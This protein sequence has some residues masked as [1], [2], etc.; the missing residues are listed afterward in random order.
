M[1]YL[2]FFA[3]IARGFL[4]LSRL[5]TPTAAGACLFLFGFTGGG[6]PL[7]AQ[8][9]SYP[10]TVHAFAVSNQGG[11]VLASDAANAETGY[12]RDR[13]NTELHIT[14]SR[15]DTSSDQWLY[16]EF[17][18]RI[19]YD[20]SELFPLRDSNGNPVTEYTRGAFVFFPVGQG[21]VTRTHEVPLTPGARFDPATYYMVQVTVERGSDLRA[22]ANTFSLYLPHF[23]H[24]EPDDEAVHVLARQEWGNY[25]RAF[26]VRTMAGGES[27][28]V[29]VP[30]TLYRWDNFEGSNTWTTIPVRFDFVLREAGTGD[31]VPLVTNTRT[32]SPWMYSYRTVTPRE[33]YT[34]NLSTTLEIE[35]AGGVQLKSA[36][37][38]Y[39]LEVT[40]SHEEVSGQ[41]YQ[42]S[43]TRT[44]ASRQL[45]HF[46]GTLYFDD[47]E[48]E[49][50]GITNEP[51]PDGGGLTYVNTTLSI[52]GDAGVVLYD[53]RFTF[54]GSTHNVRLLDDGSA[55]VQSG[56]ASIDKD[57]EEGEPDTITKAGVV[58]Q[59]GSIVLDVNGAR[60]HTVAFF[61][62]G[63]GMA[64]GSIQP[65]R[66]LI[67]Y[68][69]FIN[70]SLD[71]SLRPFGTHE[72]NRDL[73][74]WMVD[75][76][77]PFFIESRSIAWNADSG[78]FTVAADN[79]RY[80][81]KLWL[82]SLEYEEEQGVIANPGATTR[83]SNDQYY[84]FVNGW[85]SEAV[86]RAG[87]N[88]NAEMDFELSL[89]PG[90]FAPHF[91]LTIAFEWT[92]N[93]VIRIA[94][95]RVVP[96]ESY[97]SG[98][99]TMPIYYFGACP[100]GQ[101]D[102]GLPYRILGFQP[103]E[104][105]LSFTPLGGLHAAGDL[106]EAYEL[107]WGIIGE[108]Q[109]AHRTDPFTR[110]NFYMSGHFFP[111][112]G[113]QREWKDAASVL[114]LSGVDPADT[115]Q[116]EQPGTVAYRDGLGDYAGLNF[117]VEGDNF[118][119]ASLLG[120]EP[121]DFLLTQ[122][123]KYYVRLAG[124]SGIHESQP[125][126]FTAPPQIYGY[127]ITFTNY[128]L[129]FLSNLNHESRTNGSVSLPNPSDIVQDFEELTFTCLGHLDR[130]EP[131]D[132]DQPKDLAYWNQEIETLAIRFA[133]N[134]GAAC[135]LN[136]G[137]LT[138][139]IGTEV[140][141][142]ARA[143]YGELGFHSDGNLV[144]PADDVEGVTSRLP[145]P[146]GLSLAGPGEESYRLEPVGGLYFNTFEPGNG[147]APEFGFA[148]VA[149]RLSVPFFRAIEA[150]IHTTG[151][152]S[153]HLAGGWPNHG[154]KDGNDDSFFTHTGFDPGNRAFPP[155]I[156]A[157]VYRN[158]DPSESSQKV[159]LAR[160]RQSWLGVVNFDYPLVW[161]RT[162][163]SFRSVEEAPTDLLVLEVE[164][165]VEY[166]SAESA[167]LAFGVSYDGLPR[168]N[169]SNM[170]VN[171]I[172]EQ[173][174]VAE[175]I[176]QAAREQVRDTI[177]GGLENLS[178]MLRDR[179]DEFFEGVLVKTVDPVV[180]NLYIKLND[181]Y[182]ELLAA[183]GS[184]DD[185]MDAKADALEEYLYNASAGV[186]STLTEALARIA[187]AVEQGEGILEEVDERLAW[188]QAGIDSL[189]GEIHLDGAQDVLIR[190]YQAVDIEESVRG[191]LAPVTPN[192]NRDL[193]GDLVGHLIDQLAPEFASAIGDAL[194][195]PA[196]ALNEE[197]NGLLEQA[198]PAIDRV[199]E[200]LETIHEIVG[201]MRAKVEF[202]GEVFEEMQTRIA[203]MTGEI[204]RIAEES[205]EAVAAFFEEI[206][207]ARP[208]LAEALEDAA[209]PF[210]EYTAEE[211][212][213]RIRSEI[214]DRFN[215]SRI[216][217]EVHLMLKQR[218]Y[219]LDADVR[220][221]IDTAFQEVNNVVRN[222]LASTMAELESEI[223]GLLGDLE[224]YVGA[225]EID[226]YAH[227][228][229]DALRLL[230]LNGRFQWQVPD[231]LEFRGYLQVKQ[232]NSEG[233]GG[234]EFTGDE[235]VTEVTLGALDVG[236]GWISPGLRADVGTKFS[237]AAGPFEVKGLGG[238]FEMTGGELEFEAF[239]ITHLGAA[240]AFGEFE[241]YLSAST[242]L[243]FSE[244][245]LAG[246]IFFGRT[247]SL[248]PIELW[249]PDA[250]EVL[251][252]GGMQT[253]TGAYVYGEGWIPISE[254]LLGIPATCMFNISAGI[255]AG[256]FYFQEGP[257]YG[258]K[259]LAGISGEALCVVSVKGELKM[260]GVKQG[261]DF[262]FSGQGRVS[263]K[264]GKCPFC[265][266]FGKTIKAKYIDNSWDVSL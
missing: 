97:L 259:I 64:D 140:T 210:E 148:S 39:I 191:L 163:S 246:G 154:W 90:E 147:E 223:N 170:L 100:D 240:V 35:P 227:I 46:S 158:P 2:F 155:G 1:H 150:Q 251:G 81:Q 241:N 15:A 38:E 212:K 220:E 194:D 92:G 162:T 248:A 206:H 149:A 89:G 47:I 33:P 50:S 112:N 52:A 211:I 167:E 127:D 26:A 106:F 53:D 168:L 25:T 4:L 160:A 209:S 247:C 216:V 142:F 58:V 139:G 70:R 234:C 45:L 87:A 175:A 256:A 114:L 86:F 17:T 156:D 182:N 34:R 119:G 151:G 80:N 235:A 233:S 113:R 192:G 224:Q 266:K 222:L 59:R 172:E 219:E 48:T 159:Y 121:M 263:G 128:G 143:F 42:E 244:Y 108:A 134:P 49:F 16:Y 124:V 208:S 231:E 13:V 82:D 228:N 187:G 218:L 61:P 116:M 207:E 169:I 185:W 215:G 249:D 69:F 11:Y 12:D 99:A 18:Y 264:A 200:V 27:F 238:S 30:Y 217:A 152:D 98:V 138:L 107:D 229:G 44:Y 199:V 20:G 258:G 201:E 250:A 252:G 23:I 19:H 236:L 76:S 57:L 7:A 56:V 131:P 67:P 8:Q 262:R 93:G 79:V 174:G 135:D 28:R 110:A 101:C 91:P 195:E 120:G 66:M 125:D 178:V 83:R 190:N 118:G 164:H 226:G 257:T 213:A 41:P 78:E 261:D 71:T 137:F 115:A 88:G 181:N 10:E 173:T 75:E 117:R 146:A 68:L 133:R 196:S 166:L 21:E 22:V 130:A 31:E 29:N 239:A 94:D 102:Y 105:R 188:V 183:G 153:F 145:A 84:R 132:D 129:S 37:E 230:R 242:G 73:P 232:L 74:F 109:S 77:K 111:E 5:R 243:R 197:L 245:Q 184:A 141:T 60:G 32:V 40:L 202:G 260:I 193:I 225:G 179:M 253:F 186:E 180:D 51:E 203:G 165:R 85:S 204:N 136:S 95:G 54:G 176:A 65:D 103:D 63:L 205:R 43:N 177:A 221:A 55:V 157:A 255:G 237:F 122:R 14:H 254:A 6:H 104:D 62:Q 265:V 9:P 214:H 126:A 24:E 36:T 123:S 161:N 198:E 96:E 189:I 72:F 3:V 171:A 144:V